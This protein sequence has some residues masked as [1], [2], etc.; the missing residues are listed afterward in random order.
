MTLPYLRCICPYSTTFCLTACITGRF[1]I[2]CTEECHCKDATEDCQL[3]NGHC[4]SGCAKYFIGD[5]CQG[6]TCCRLTGCN[7]T[8]DQ[9]WKTQTNIIII[10]CHVIENS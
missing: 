2:N 8:Y 5:T 9:S 1:G 10:R 3:K 4:E 6:K 7:L